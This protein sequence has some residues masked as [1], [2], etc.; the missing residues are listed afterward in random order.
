MLNS[1]KIFGAGSIGNHLANAAR[2]LG[3]DVVLCDI[4]SAALERARS[5]IYPSRYG[6]WDPDIK[7]SL[8]EQA[9]K[10]EC[11][12]VIV[13]TPPDSH[14]ELALNA[15]DE[16]PKALLI[17]KPLSTPS[18]E[19]LPELYAKADSLGVAVF[20]GY[21][22]AVS[23]SITKL[24][25]LVRDSEYGGLITLDVEFREHWQGIFSAHPWLDGPK[26]SYL[27]FWQRG[28]GACGEHSHAINMWQHL[29][30]ICDKGR[31]SNVSAE[32]EYVNDGSCEYDRLC[33]VHVETESGMKGRIVQDVVTFPVRKEAF[34]QFEKGA[35]HWHCGGDPT[36]DIVSTSLFPEP[37][38]QILVEKTRPDDF[39]AEL[40]H[41]KS[42]VENGSKSPI[43]LERGLETMLVIAASHLS[44]R[45]GRKV[46]I[47]Y[48]RGP[49]ASALQIL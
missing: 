47:D 35:L 42:A 32:I 46:S 30:D 44:A 21:D 24:E 23:K 49:V 29:A 26:D 41:I 4:D 2:R 9:P 48:S 28:G 12:L 8:V 10:N 14:I 7:L 37:M 43:S 16:K 3:M 25:S 6:S 11:D 31:I 45:E 22:H 13:G 36:G 18:L 33:L 15:L 34:M 5:D 27:G 1:T 38:N 17:E 19:S 40:S 20:V 39:I